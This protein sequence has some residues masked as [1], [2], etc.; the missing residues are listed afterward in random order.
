MNNKLISY[1]IDFT[2]FLIQKIKDKKYIKNVIL[3]GSVSREE[4][5]KNSDVDIFIDVVDEENK[6]ENEINKILN[7]YKDSSKIKNYWKPLGVDNEIKINVG[8]LEKWKE[9]NPSIIANG[10]VLYGKYKS[11]IKEG[12]HSVFFVWENIS[13]NSKR[14]LFNKQMFGYKQNNKFYN[15]L[16]K[17]F[18]GERLG[19]GSIIVPLE[20]SN[21][22]HPIFK[23]YKITVKIKKVLE[24]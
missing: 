7:D 24:Y 6:L 23:K 9:L 14:V 2:S 21:V 19:K 17:K 10:I 20:Y 16:L 8:K 11:E 4:S 15:G 3:F 1:S 5:N 13:P 18:G 12:K 22:F